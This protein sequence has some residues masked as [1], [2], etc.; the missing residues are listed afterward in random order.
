MTTDHKPIHMD[1]VDQLKVRVYADRQTMGNDA[2]QH[3]AVIIKE[4]QQK[5]KQVRMVFAAAPS[6]INFLQAL[7]LK[8]GID[9]SNITAFH[10]D[11]YIGLPEGAPEK[12]SRFLCDR[13]FDLVKPGELHLINSSNS[14]EE[15]C[16]GTEI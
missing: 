14:I 13:I 10:M 1:T 9:W 2:A 3:V 12:F 15:E 16:N 11:E 8:D 6:Q 7:I 4:L 5:Q